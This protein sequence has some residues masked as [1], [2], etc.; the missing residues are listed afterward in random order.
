MVK[1]NRLITPPFG[2]SILG[3]ITRA[4]VLEIAHDLGVVVE[5]RTMTRDELYVAD[6][7]FLCGTAAEVTPVR[8]IDGRVI[9]PGRPGEISTMIANTYFD[10]VKGSTSAHPEWRHP[11]SL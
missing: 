5:E 6:E 2:S 9:G 7:I 11:Y 8:E 3:G 1:N 4:S 10:I